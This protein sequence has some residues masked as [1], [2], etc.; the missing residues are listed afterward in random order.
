MILDDDS[1]VIMYMSESGQQAVQRAVHNA[2]IKLFGEPEEEQTPTLMILDYDKDAT[3]SDGQLIR[4]KVQD[5]PI[6]SV[7]VYNSKLH[8]FETIQQM[9]QGKN[10]KS[11]HDYL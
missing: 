9:I 3:Y 10:A 1:K 5:R 2:F 4:F 11:I 6:T 7:F 8:T